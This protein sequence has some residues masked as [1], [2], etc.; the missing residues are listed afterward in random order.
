MQSQSIVIKPM[1]YIG[2]APQETVYFYGVTR[3]DTTGFLTLNKVN[4]DTAISA[5]E[6]LDPAKVSGTGKPFDSFAEGVDFFEGRDATHNIQYDGLRYE[7]YKWTTDDLYYYVDDEGQ[8]CVRV[9]EVYN[10]SEGVTTFVTATELLPNSSPINLGAVNTG[11]LLDNALDLD[12]G[13]VSDKEIT[14]TTIDL[15]TVV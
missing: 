4:M 5:I 8:L 3:D 14:Q 15:S 11:N 12:L 6:I 1:R 10:Y 7:Q 13:K 9:N 2:R